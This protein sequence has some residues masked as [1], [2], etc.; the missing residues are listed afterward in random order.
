MGSEPDDPPLGTCP[1]WCDKPAGHPWEDE[2]IAGPVRYHAYRV[3]LDK[4]NAI[5]VDSIEQYAGGATVYQTDVVLDV[6]SPS[7]L[8][9][10]MARR[11]YRLM[12]EAVDR[13]V[14][15]RRTVGGYREAR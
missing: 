14:L 4:Y 5:G 3:A 2:W 15:W 9:I 6:E 11:A 12:G 1:S 8:K 10:E 13:A 7:S